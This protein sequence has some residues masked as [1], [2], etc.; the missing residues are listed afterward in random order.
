M[1]DQLQVNHSILKLEGAGHHNWT[2]NDGLMLSAHTWGERKP[3]TLPVVCL[4]GLTRNTR[5]FYR[6]AKHLSDQGHYVVAMDYRGRGLS[7][8]AADYTSYSLPQEAEDIEA[9]LT[10]LGIEDYVL[11]G[12]SR[13]GLHAMSFG[14]RHKG[15]LKGAILN[16]IGPE[17]PENALQ[18]IV[19]SVGSKMTE[20]NWEEA[21]ARLKS[22]YAQSFTA[23]SDQDWL[24]AACQFY[25]ETP[26]GLRLSYDAHLKDALMD[27][28]KATP[29]VDLWAL[30][31][32]LKDLP[33]LLIRGS[34]SPLLSERTAQAMQERHPEMDMHTVAQEGHAPLLWGAAVQERIERFLAEL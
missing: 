26:E 6:V 15:R 7:Q 2:A 9:G 8:Y 3:G 24:D 18:W 5:D 29:E 23:L 13:G 28:A 4:P 12:T 30:F 21:V 31:D 20:P 1:S 33:H 16:D 10:S 22:L 32:G 11:L 17:L 27:T 34:N 19:N 14:Y 25:E